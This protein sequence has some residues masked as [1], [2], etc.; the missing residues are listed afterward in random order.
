MR[1]AA[2]STNTMPGR[3]VTAVAKIPI[4]GPSRIRARRRRSCRR[5]DMRN[6]AR[7]FQNW[8]SIRSRLTRISRIASA[9]LSRARL[10]W[11]ALYAPMVT[12]GSPGERSQFGQDMHS[13]RGIAASSMPC[14]AQ[15]ADGA[16]DLLVVGQRA[17]PVV[18]L[19][20]RLLLGGRVA[21]V[22]P[23]GCAVADDLDHV[24]FGD[25]ALQ[26]HPPQPS[27]A[28]G[29][30]AGDI[31]RERRIL[32]AH[33]RQ[34]VVAV[35]AITVVESETGEAAGEIALPHPAVRFVHGNDVHAERACTS[36]SRKNARRDF[37]VPVGLEHIV[38]GG[39][40]VMQHED[41]ADA[42]QD[43]P[44]HMM[45]AGEVQRVEADAEDRRYCEA[46]SWRWLGRS[47]RIR[48]RDV[49]ETVEQTVIRVAETATIR[50][51]GLTH[52]CE[53]AFISSLTPRQGF[54]LSAFCQ[55]K[56]WDEPLSE[57][58]T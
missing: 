24:G 10:Q 47:R 35:V 26:R 7:V 38:A 52:K 34:R 20:E 11:L 36:T 46:A 17:Q 57:L 6:A 23:Q 21:G 22:K 48:L 42:R 33:H 4:R 25:D 44:Q 19:V 9:S 5:R 16:L 39:T 37:E 49:A 30:I 2:F 45:R 51:S 28:I 27:V 56:V 32:R 1:C 3:V 53:A 43:R 58:G 15:L 54:V 13:S 8:L 41:G 40:D 14:R 29:E 12:S 50:K 31:D 18:D 55:V